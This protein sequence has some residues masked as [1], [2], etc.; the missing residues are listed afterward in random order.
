MA[1]FFALITECQL[2]EAVT[3]FQDANADF[4]QG[5]LLAL[6][7]VDCVEYFGKMK[8][9]LYFNRICKLKEKLALFETAG[10]SQPPAPAPAAAPAPRAPAPAKSSADS[11]DEAP[12]PFARGGNPRGSPCFEYSQ[13]RCVREDCKFSHEGTISPAAPTFD[14]AGYSGDTSVRASGAGTAVDSSSGFGSGFGGDA[15]F[16]GGASEPVLVQDVYGLRVERKDTRATCFQFVKGLCNRGADCKFVHA[17]IETKGS[18]GAYS[19]EA[20]LKANKKGPCGD[21]ASTG[22]CRRGGACI[23]SHDPNVKPSRCGDFFKGSCTRN[24]CRFSHD[25]DAPEAPKRTGNDCFAFAKGACTQGND[26]KFAHPGVHTGK[27]REKSDEECGQWKRGTCTHG[28]SC[29]FQHVGEPGSPPEKQ[30]GECGQF[31]RG[32]CTRGDRCKFQHVGE[33]P[34]I[35]GDSFGGGGDTAPAVDTAGAGGWGT[36]AGGEAW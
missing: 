33:A 23:F 10:A 36:D 24:P 2:T 34:V 20:E 31:K 35:G 19:Y 17:G 14:A 3:F 15:S 6:Q 16:G 4:T 26:C 12:A 9:P 22:A 28:D 1:N 29:R 27:A 11:W 7:R 5:D 25:A 21:F 13:G 30:E 32:E 8:G 18:S